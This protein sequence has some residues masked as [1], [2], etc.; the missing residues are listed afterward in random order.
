MEN[1]TTQIYA[2]NS[3]L[4]VSVCDSGIRQV[5]CRGVCKG[6]CRGWHA[7]MWKQQNLNRFERMIF[8][9][10]SELCLVMQAWYLIM[11][12]KTKTDYNPWFGRTLTWRW[13]RSEEASLPR[14]FMTR[15]MLAGV[16]VGISCTCTSHI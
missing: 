4:L 5:G 10:D 7:L 13:R 9:Q 3:E 2:R 15:S 12:T 8:E 16:K 11:L 14:V 6:V 1:E